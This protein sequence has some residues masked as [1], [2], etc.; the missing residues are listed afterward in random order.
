MDGQFDGLAGLLSELPV[1]VTLNI[2]SADEHVGDIE[3]YIRTVKE[4][5]RSTYNTL[6]FTHVPPRVVIELAKREVF[7]LNSFPA[8]NGIS[9]TLSP[10]TIVTGLTISLDRHCRFDFGEY[11][12][13]HEEHDNT[14]AP[15]TVGALALR[16]TGNAQGSFYVLSL[17]SGRF[18]TRLHATPLPM[19]QEVIDQVHR[20]ARRQKANPGLVFLD[21][22]SASFCR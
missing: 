20:L 18:L 21:R 22:H 11:V 7:W 8:A 4:R 2:T 15:R 10:R 19:P 9:D 12:Q 14:M 13:T 5:M 1:P 6:P 3:R 17:N 16:P